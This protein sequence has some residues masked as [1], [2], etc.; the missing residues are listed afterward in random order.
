MSVVVCVLRRET[1]SECVCK[2]TAPCFT[3]R[4]LEWRS[5]GKDGIEEE[6]EDGVG[7]RDEEG[8]DGERGGS[9]RDDGDAGG[10]ER[11]VRK[12]RAMPT[13]KWGAAAVL[14]H[15]RNCVIVTGGCES[16]TTKE[17]RYVQKNN[18]QP[19]THT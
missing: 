10:T 16:R 13:G 1:V 19:A 3:W 14:S 5:T 17:P 2:M 11:Q 18:L 6:R 9:V 7:E 15:R 4:R 12:V 8:G